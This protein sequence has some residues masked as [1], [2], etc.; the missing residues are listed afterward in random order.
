MDF[1]EYK[2]DKISKLS[3]GT[4]QF[5]LD[6]GVA[7]REGKPSQEKVNE[8]ID[9]VV[10]QNVNC[11]D[12]AQ[13]YGTSEEVLGESIKEIQNLF[14][15]SKL[16]SKL[17]KD[18]L[19]VYISTSLKKLNISKLHGLL[20]HDSEV[21]Y[22]WNNNYSDLVKKL[23][24]EEKIK[25]FGVSIYSDSDFQLAIKNKDIDLIQV[26]FNI[27]DQRAI[28]NH[29]FKEAASSNKLIFIRSIYLQGL[30][31]MDRDKLP[32]NLSQAKPYIEQ[33]ERVCKNLNMSKNQLALAFVNTIAKKSILLFG[34]DN[35][36]QAKQNLE[37]FNNLSLLTQETLEILYKLFSKIDEKIYNPT[38]W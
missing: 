23:K 18:A 20:L 15:V 21:L 14:I 31:L 12:T 28:H 30:L 27:F 3:L 4:V 34:C 1:I 9:Y 24:Q 26:P 25:H 2:G 22:T 7:N 10:S 6:Y 38:R 13:A 37:N 36:E 33:L 16:E 17:F 5:G 29:W 19:D 8:I 11:F 35:L 32:N